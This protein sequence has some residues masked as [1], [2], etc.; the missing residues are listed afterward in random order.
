MRNQYSALTAE[1]PVNSEP[2]QASGAGHLVVN[3]I[4]TDR[5]GTAR[6]LKA[7]DSLAASL[8]ASIKLLAAQAVPF[9]LNLDEPQVSVDFTERLLSDLVGGLDQNGVEINPR[10]YLCRNPF[11]TINQVL[12]PDSLVVIGGRKRWWPTAASRMARALRS[13]GHQV[14]W[15]DLRNRRASELP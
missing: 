3:V 4:F 1:G 9:R 5:E 6:A 10:L 7:A 8:G 15:I 14:F 13:R 2:T 11:E 12:R